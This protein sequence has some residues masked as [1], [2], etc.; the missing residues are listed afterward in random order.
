MSP[1]VAK[2]VTAL[3]ATV[4]MAPAVFAQNNPTTVDGTTLLPQHRWDNAKVMSK[5]VKLKDDFLKTSPDKE[6]Q[7]A[8]GSVLTNIPN[9]DAK[10]TKIM[11]TWF[12]GGPTPNKIRAE[13]A[14]DPETKNFIPVYDTILA[15]VMANKEGVVY[16]VQECIKTGER[17]FH[18]N[19]LQ[20]LKDNTDNLGAFYKKSNYY[21]YDRVGAE[22]FNPGTDKETQALKISTAFQGWAVLEAIRLNSGTDLM[23]YNPMSSLYERSYEQMLAIAESRVRN[24]GFDSLMVTIDAVSDGKFDMNMA[25]KSASGLI[26]KGRFGQNFQETREKLEA[27][28]PEGSGPFLSAIFAGVESITSGIKPSTS[29]TQN[30][31]EK[32]LV[33]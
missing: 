31:G 6:Y 5:L 29:G 30:N 19:Y 13:L 18:L 27:L 1:R 33:L 8:Q 15:Q 10:A 24:P 2:S 9:D 20:R 11:V 16:Y 3:L 7:A 17:P 22:V 4:A 28:S 14:K 26:Q 32:L 25:K 23:M 12:E 21:N